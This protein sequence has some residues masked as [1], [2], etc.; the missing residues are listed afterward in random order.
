MINN[1]A[2]EYN[3]TNPPYYKTLP[4]LSFVIDQ[5]R[6]LGTLPAVAASLCDVYTS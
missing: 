5:S 1:Y 3:D 2:H 4:M 6:S